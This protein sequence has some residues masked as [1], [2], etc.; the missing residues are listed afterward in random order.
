MSV[1]NVSFLYSE[2]KYNVGQRV[3]SNTK[4]GANKNRRGV[5]IKSGKNN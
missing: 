2:A 3:K 5:V 4:T 1:F